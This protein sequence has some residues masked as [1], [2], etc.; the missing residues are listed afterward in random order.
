MSSS[1][2]SA[3]Q[4][5]GKMFAGYGTVTLGPVQLTGLM[6]PRAIKV[7]GKQ[8]LNINTMPGG[9][10]RASAMGP[11]FEDKAWS[12]YIDGQDADT[13]VRTLEKM[14]MSGAVFTLA[15]GVY[16]YSVVIEEFLCDSRLVTPYPYTI[17]CKVLADNSFPTGQSGFG[18]EEK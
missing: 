7:G 9:A 12:G 10:V 5:V 11:V 13:I 6:I 1:I 15:W 17:S 3:L 14:W 18:E 4:A 8:S 16:S 2:V